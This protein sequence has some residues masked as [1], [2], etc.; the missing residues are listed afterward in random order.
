MQKL[1][2]GGN[3]MKQRLGES[4]KRRVLE[5]FAFS[6]FADKLD[7]IV[8]PEPETE[9]GDYQEWR[10]ADLWVLTNNFMVNLLFLKIY[11]IVWWNIIV[12]KS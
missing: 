9:A 3:E 4:G 7:A 1:V 8:A 6:V 5:N 2:S 11:W 12:L 10:G